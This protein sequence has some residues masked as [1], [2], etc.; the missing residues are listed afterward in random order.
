[1]PATEEK[2][3]R[4]GRRQGRRAAN[5]VHGRKRRYERTT[6]IGRAQKNL[7]KVDKTLAL[8]KNRLASWGAVSHDSG[9]GAGPNEHLDEAVSEVSDASKLVGCAV[10]ALARLEKSGFVPARRSS[11]V[12]FKAEDEVKI[13]DKHKGK[14][15]EVYPAQVLDGLVV[16]KVLP[17]GEI[18]VEHAR[19]GK[20]RFAFIVPKSHLARRA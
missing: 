1:M 11:V 18:A 2:G 15:L 16:S 5:G 4:H 13:V 17:T 19:G 6:P 8:V 10:D 14:Y 20:T 7:A 9:S 12:S 3:G